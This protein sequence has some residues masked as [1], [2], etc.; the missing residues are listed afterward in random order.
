MGCIHMTCHHWNKQ[1]DRHKKKCCRLG[2]DSPEGRGFSQ[3]PESVRGGDL[4]SEKMTQIMQ[5]TQRMVVF[6]AHSLSLLQPLVVQHTLIRIKH[7]VEKAERV[8]RPVFLFLISYPWF[9]FPH[10]CVQTLR[11]FLTCALFCWFVSKRRA[12]V[13]SVDDVGPN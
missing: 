13:T 7:S 11:Q 1:T 12:A 3:I 8:K 4:A 10:D 2:T 5:T 6:P 9:V